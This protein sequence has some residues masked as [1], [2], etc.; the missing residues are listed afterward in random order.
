VLQADPSEGAS[1]GRLLARLQLE[2]WACRASFA[3]PTQRDR[4]AAKL[5]SVGAHHGLAVA[6]LLDWLARDQP[7]GLCHGD[8][9]PHNIV[10]V[11]HRPVLV[12][13]FDAGV[14]AL[15]AETARTLLH[16]GPRAWGAD[17]PQRDGRAAL[18]DAYLA[19]ITEAGELDGDELDRWTTVQLIARIAE[20]VGWGDLAEVRA[21]LERW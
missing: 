17:D 5:R 2:L 6:P 9:H 13:W 20:G 21:R 10:L 7:L 16:V 8:L 1:L 15:A 4:L 12:D 18:H 3:L 11:E 19:A 14:G